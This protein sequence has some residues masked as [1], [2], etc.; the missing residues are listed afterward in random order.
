MATGPINLGLSGQSW[1][2]AIEAAQILGL[3]HVGE[4][5]PDQ[6]RVAVMMHTVA[7]M[8]GRVVGHP[9]FPGQSGAIPVPRQATLGSSSAGGRILSNAAIR[10]LMSSSAADDVHE[11]A[12]PAGTR[13]VLGSSVSYKELV[14]FGRAEIRTEFDRLSD[15]RTILD[16]HL[17]RVD[18]LLQE[19]EDLKKTDAHGVGYDERMRQAHEMLVTFQAYSSPVDFSRLLGMLKDPAKIDGA[20]TDLEGIKY[21][22]MDASAFG[23]RVGEL[24]RAALLKL[25]EI[26]L[27][28][29]AAPDFQFGLKKVAGLVQEAHKSLGF[30]AKDLGDERAL[31][32]YGIDRP[33]MHLERAK[34]RLI[35]A[36]ALIVEVVAKLTNAGQADDAARAQAR[37]DHVIGSKINFIDDLIARLR[38]GGTGVALE[39]K[40]EMDAAPFFA[41]QIFTLEVLQATNEVT[42]LLEERGLTGQNDP[43]FQ[44]HIDEA[45][46]EGRAA[47]VS[48]QNALRI[49]EE[50]DSQAPDLRQKM[51]DA[52]DQVKSAQ[53]GLQGALSLMKFGATSL[54]RAASTLFDPEENRRIEAE[55]VRVL[56]TLEQ[57]YLAG[58][59]AADRLVTWT[60]QRAVH[61]SEDDLAGFYQ[62]MALAAV[63][64]RESVA[65][66][67]AFMSQLAERNLETHFTWAESREAARP[68]LLAINSDHRRRVL[69]RDGMTLPSE[70]KGRGVFYNVD[71][72]LAELGLS[73]L[74]DSLPDR[75]PLVA[76]I[77]AEDVRRYK[78]DKVPLAASEDVPAIEATS[79]VHY[80][81]MRWRTD[82]YF[83]EAGEALPTDSHVL[84]LTH[85]AGTAN[86][87]AASM[88]K[89]AM[90]MMNNYGQN[91]GELATGSG[92]SVRSMSVIVVGLPWHGY[93][94]RD[95]KR[96]NRV[97][98]RRAAHAALPADAQIGDVEPALELFDAMLDAYLG[99]GEEDS[100]APIG[101][102]GRSSG[103]VFAIAHR[104]TRHAGRD[105]TGK[106]YATPR[107]PF[108]FYVNVSGYAYSDFWFWHDTYATMRLSPVAK[109]IL[110]YEWIMLADYGTFGMDLTPDA[111]SPPILHMAAGI[112]GSY[113]HAVPANLVVEPQPSPEVMAWAMGFAE[114]MRFIFPVNIYSKLSAADLYEHGVTLIRGW[115]KRLEGVLPAG[116]NVDEFWAGQVAATNPARERSLEDHWRH[117][118]TTDPQAR[119][120]WDKDAEHDMLG[121][122]PHRV[123]YSRSVV[124]RSLAALFGFFDDVKAAFDTLRGKR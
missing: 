17:A 75:I 115:R 66:Y 21:I 92:S 14:T 43:Y 118:S 29:R 10:K 30:A 22:G 28:G 47:L 88:L 24:T 52:V 11:S 77:D 8:R 40:G 69:L 27:V 76:R 68:I 74:R 89:A 54:K 110:G 62:H 100:R 15:G 7:G 4:L 123:D 96:F 45:S 2:A 63:S 9:Y 46:A 58:T 59:V 78:E 67:E 61:L 121:I 65:G 86:S 101:F 20:K 84:V 105:I 12:L 1:A 120:H 109:N 90:S 50:T 111:S 38:V 104:Q 94:P 71:E 119:L 72:D 13:L 114:R 108:D 35:Q 102:G 82:M 80:Y 98:E 23:E 44:R 99:Y 34:D 16:E 64:Y 106:D 19:K 37:Y 107:R 124:E 51:N 39:V 95:R 42:V 6:A 70:Q 85:G 112:D 73:D 117:V 56:K 32:R 3:S 49:L 60:V 36:G 48:L 53:P 113:P 26:G 93:G 57:D 55:I 87:T 18:A 31:R 83:D 97:G 25:E 103:G 33:I 116:S 5:S 122:K 91:A 79:M 81:D 41:A